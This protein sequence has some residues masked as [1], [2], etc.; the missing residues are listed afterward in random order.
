[1]VLVV[2]DPR[3]GE[4]GH[5]GKERTS[6]ACSVLWDRSGPLGLQVRGSRFSVGVNTRLSAADSGLSFSQ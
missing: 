5:W 2:G 4:S 6:L 3:I 1:M